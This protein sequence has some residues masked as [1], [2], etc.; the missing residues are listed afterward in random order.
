MAIQTG[1]EGKPWYIGAITGA[2]VAAAIVAGVWYLLVSPREKQIEAKTK[3]LDALQ[4]QISEGRAA[5]P[6]QPLRPRDAC[7]AHPRLR[8]MKY[9]PRLK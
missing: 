1:L 2:I 3:Q 9:S 5:R 4:V 8:S 7:K 6:L